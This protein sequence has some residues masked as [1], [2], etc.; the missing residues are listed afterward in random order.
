MER[1]EIIEKLK[2]ILTSVLKHDKFDIHDNLSA[3]DVEGWDSLS[4]MTIVTEIEKEFN[5]KFKLKELNKLKNITSLIELI[6]L[7]LTN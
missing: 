3:S 4:H 6:E 7:K 5:I 2:V 1:K